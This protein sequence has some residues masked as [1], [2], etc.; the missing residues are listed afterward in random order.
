MLTTVRVRRQLR[1][2]V[3]PAG[4]DWPPHGHAY[5][6]DH[7]SREPVLNP[8]PC[9]ELRTRYRLSALLCSPRSCITS[10]AI[11]TYSL[12]CAIALISTS[13]YPSRSAQ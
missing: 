5:I 9:Q 1:V 10:T 6:P 7:D 3:A 4:Y 2:K 13:R 12:V 11:P 8:P